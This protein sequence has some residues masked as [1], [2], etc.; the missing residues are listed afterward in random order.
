MEIS[1]T[2]NIINTDR[3]PSLVQKKIE[4]LKHTE[5]DKKLMDVCREF[6]SIFIYM[7]LKEMKKT[8]PDDNG[9]IE[10]SQGTRIFEEMHL[11]ELSKEMTKGDNSV[12][13]AKMLYNQFKNGYV[14]L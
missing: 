5:D 2:N 13:I 8:V 6:E 9:L 4:N 11:E 12:G 14:R 3:D 7:M 10:K 1:P